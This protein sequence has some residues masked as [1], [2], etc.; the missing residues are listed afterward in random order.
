MIKIRSL[1]IE[2]FHINKIF[3]YICNIMKVLNVAL[4]F[5]GGKDCCLALHRIKEKSY[6]VVVLVTFAPPNTI[7]RAHPIEIIK[8]QA[9]A[10]GIPHTICLIEGPN[11]LQDYRNKILQLK[12]KYY[13]EGLVTGD[14]LDIC[15]NFMNKAC[16][17]IINLIKPLWK[18]NRKHLLNDIWSRDFDIIITCINKNKL[19][20]KKEINNISGVGDK[21]TIKWIKKH[22]DE[23][24]ADMSG[25]Y[26]E[27]HTM[28]L[29][30]PLFINGKIK[31]LGYPKQEGNFIFYQI[32]SSELIPK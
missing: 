18:E 16:Q 6:N 3:L 11:Y 23:N 7:F 31:V 4:S 19:S 27:W 13:I 32:E 22:V 30:C 12:Q 5:T 1:K 2:L 9:E 26:G 28:V 8:L 10:I 17:N 24:K 20:S 14:I 25:E 21:L 15:D 29:N